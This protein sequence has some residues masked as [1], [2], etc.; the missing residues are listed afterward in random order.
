MEETKYISHLGYDYT[1]YVETEEDKA[2]F[3]KICELEKASQRPAK[4]CMAQVVECLNLDRKLRGKGRKVGKIM[5]QGNIA[6][7]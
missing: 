1:K 7:N 3:A 4:E 5:L 2:D 6:N